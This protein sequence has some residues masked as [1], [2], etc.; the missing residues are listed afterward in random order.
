MSSILNQTHNQTLSQKRAVKQVLQSEV[1]CAHLLLQSLN[2]EYEALA[3]HHTATLE[4]VVRNKQDKIQQL[5]SATREREKLLSTSDGVTVFN[6][7]E[8]NK[9]YQFNGD[10]QLIDLWNELVDVAEK[11]RLKNR[12]NGSIV[13][14]VSRQSRHAL[15]I[16]H[17]IVPGASSHSEIYDQSGHTQGF[18]SKRSLVHV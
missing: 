7:E 5:E 12:V 18:A 16:L 17:G 14:V 3:E 13:E 8:R 10:K 11:C 1:D 9:H 6:D 15:D 4:D 2:Q